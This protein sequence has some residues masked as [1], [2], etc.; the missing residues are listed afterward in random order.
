MVN[1]RCSNWKTILR[2][3]NLRWR[4]PPVPKGP[5][6]CSKDP[7]RPTEALRGDDENEAA[8]YAVS[9][10]ELKEKTDFSR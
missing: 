5:Q 4:Q 3:L 1:E 10:E 6:G 9:P 7:E 8:D 2:R